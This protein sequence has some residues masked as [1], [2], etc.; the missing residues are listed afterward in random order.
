[1][2]PTYLSIPSPQTQMTMCLENEH[3][4]KV[5][6][7]DLGGVNGPEAE[8]ESSEKVSLYSR[9]THPRGFSVQVKYTVIRGQFRCLSRKERERES[10][11][12]F[13]ICAEELRPPGNSFP[14]SSIKPMKFP[15]SKYRKVSLIRQGRASP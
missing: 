1:M 12:H 14:K 3:S 6:R 13:L 15:D 8:Q 2:L 4:C 11:V 9:R 7:C 5:L 10:L